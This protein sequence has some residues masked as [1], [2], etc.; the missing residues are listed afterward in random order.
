MTQLR[1]LILDKNNKPLNKCK[2]HFRGLDY[3]SNKNGEYLIKLEENSVGGLSNL[4]IKKVGYKKLEVLPFNLNNELKSSLTSILENVSDG[5]KS[6]ISGL[7]NLPKDGI[8]KA[9][10]STPKS[11]GDAIQSQIT[12]YTLDVL[13]KFTPVL[14]ALLFSLGAEKIDDLLNNKEELQQCPESEELKK[15]I[16]KRNNATKSVNT[17]YKVV[18]TSL[19]AV[20]VITGLIQVF[21]LTKGIFTSLPIPT[22]IGT[23][24]GPAGGVI[25][26]QTTGK[27]LSDVDKLNKLDKL[28]SKFEG[29]SITLLASLIILKSALNQ[30]LNMLNVVDTQLNKCIEQG[31]LDDESPLVNAQFIIFEDGDGGN[32]INNTRSVNDFILEIKNINTNTSLIQKQAIGKNKAGVVLVKGSKSYSSSNQILL[33]ELEF[34]IRSNNLKAN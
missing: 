5:N 31:I 33:D 22:T 14:G 29:I 7:S 6:Q 3:L 16:K 1:G 18:D 20:G 4:S 2:V 17:I 34:Y 10:S 26:S 32:E 9:L 21:K 12:N 11:M 28:I 27:I 13:E 25:I 24:P 8:D 19:K 15:I 30:Y 23:P